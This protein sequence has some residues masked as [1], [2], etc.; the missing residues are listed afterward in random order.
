MNFKTLKAIVFDLKNIIR[1]AQISDD[2]PISDIQIEN[3]IH[4]YR[5]VLIKQ[6][7]DKKKIPNPDYIQNIPVIELEDVDAYGDNVSIDSG[8]KK[9]RTNIQIPDSIDLNNKSGIL[10]VGDSYGTQIQ[11]IQENRVAYMNN[12]K[13]SKYIP[14]AYLKEKYIYIHNHNALRY[15]TVRGV[16]ENPVAV[17]ELTNPLTTAQSATWD[18]EYP[19]PQNMLPILKQMILKGEL[20]IEHSAPNDNEN[21][22]DNKLSSDIK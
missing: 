15:I 1:A 7:L 13:Y 16:F 4:Q 9:Y 10:F 8:Y 17:Y 3:W 2:E 6:D 5:N 22:A 18:F 12:S 21:D 20:G 11:L 19:I 14:V